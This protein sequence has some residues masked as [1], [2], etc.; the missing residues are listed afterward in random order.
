MILTSCY[1]KSFGFGHFTLLPSWY[2]LLPHASPLQPFH[3]LWNTCILAANTIRCKK[4]KFLQRGEEKRQSKARR[5]MQVH[6]SS[7]LNN[8]DAENCFTDEQPKSNEVKYLKWGNKVFTGSST[9]NKTSRSNHCHSNLT[10]LVLSIILKFS[11][12]T[13]LDCCLAEKQTC[14]C[15]NY[16]RRISKPT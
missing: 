11:S 12:L 5:K 10:V 9:Q 3:C 14:L 7:N 15:C 1:P 6:S 13:P 4:S 8:P 16:W 2:F